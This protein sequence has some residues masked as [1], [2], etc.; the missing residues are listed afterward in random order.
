MYHLKNDSTHTIF[1]TAFTFPNQ[2]YL[3]GF[4]RNNFAKDTLLAL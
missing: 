1:K 2:Q 4:A 3:K